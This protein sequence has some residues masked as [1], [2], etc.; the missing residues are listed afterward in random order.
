MRISFLLWQ[1]ST[2]PPDFPQGAL[3]GAESAT[4]HLAEK[5]SARHDV[6][7]ICRGAKNESQEIGKVSLVRVATGMPSKWLEGDEY[8]RRAM[9][10]SSERDFVVAVTCI[11]PALYSDRV[12]LHLENDLALYLPFP[13]AKAR[14]YLRKLNRIRAVSGVSNHVSRRFAA[15]FD[16]DGRITTILNG[17][18]C[19]L[20]NPKMRDRD[21]VRAQYGVQDT[22]IV[23]VYAGAI[24]ERKGLHVL[25]DA[26]QGLGDPDLRLLVLGGL[27]YSKKRSGDAVYMQEQVE[28]MRSIPGAQLVGPVSKSE[29]A[30]IL[31]SSDIFVCPSIW[32]DPCPLVCAEAQASGLPV[33][34]FDRGGIP[35]LVENGGTGL[36]S[37]VSVEHLR[38]SIRRICDDPR[39]RR[40]MGKSA[41]I[42]AERFLEWRTLAT[43]MEKVLQD[44]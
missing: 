10:H 26:M 6:E 5:L 40:R 34:G 13:R 36:I 18:D 32:Q 2:F 21:Y 19:E 31:A 8:Y 16:Y 9:A 33:V 11:E 17:A 28:R 35:E 41:R 25:L 29:M 14:I 3:G 22:D 7:I 12:A 30:R 42:R 39:S 15:E 37:P 24:H 20:F 43:K 1:Y 44:L 27:I 38:D 23:L 4:W